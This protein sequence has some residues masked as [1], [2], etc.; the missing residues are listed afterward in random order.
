MLIIRK[1]KNGLKSMLQKNKIQ[2]IFN[3]S[4]WKF[5]RAKIAEKSDNT[6]ESL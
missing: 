3:R 6:I 5:L 2:W 4:S 1:L